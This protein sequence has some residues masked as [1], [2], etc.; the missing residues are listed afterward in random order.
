MYTTGALP[1]IITIDL[2]SEGLVLH[3]P[4]SEVFRAAV[5]KALDGGQPVPGMGELL[6]YSVVLENQTSEAI[7]VATLWW[8]L[9]GA[10]RGGGA[11]TWLTDGLLDDDRHVAGPGDQIVVTPSGKLLGW[12]PGVR[13][14]VMISGEGGPLTKVTAPEPYSIEISIDSVI[15]DSGRA[16]GPDKLQTRDKM[17]FQNNALRELISVLRAKVEAGAS[18]DEVKEFLG[19]LIAP[20]PFT[21]R[22]ARDRA[23]WV[24]HTASSFMNAITEGRLRRELERKVPEFKQPPSF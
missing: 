9:R 4:A 12:I 10:L 15:F 17:F 24:Q 11:E 1:E 14:Y 7:R 3:G 6:P 18:D 20:K 2:A 23:L 22:K 13:G 21:D 16:I 5:V 19:R 8:S